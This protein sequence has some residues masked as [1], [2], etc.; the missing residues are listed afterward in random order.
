MKIRI[1][2]N[3][4]RLRLSQTEVSTFAETG[5]VVDQIQLTPDVAWQYALVSGNGAHDLAIRY[6]ANKVSVVVPGQ[7]AAAWAGS[8]QVGLESSIEVGDAEVRLLVEKDFVCLADRPD[9]DESDL[10]ANP[11]A[12]EGK[13]C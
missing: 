8:D 12:A 6:D 5:E 9:E 7:Q 3:S 13:T 10:F 1:K 11:L 4:L 2:G